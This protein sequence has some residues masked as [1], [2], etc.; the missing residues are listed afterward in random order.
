MNI[1]RDRLRLNHNTTKSQPP[2]PDHDQI[3]TTPQY[4]QHH[5]PHHNHHNKAKPQPSYNQ[6]TTKIQP[7][8]TTPTTHHHSRQLILPLLQIAIT[9]LPKR[10]RPRRPVRIKVL[11]EPRPNHPPLRPHAPDLDPVRPPSLLPAITISN[12]RPPKAPRALTLGT[13]ISSATAPRPRPSAARSPGSPSSRW[14]P[15]VPP[16]TATSR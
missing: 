5:T 7:N 11:V 1:H 14:D 8:T 12:S 4:P 2:Q 3:S 6:I 10:R 9:H 15:T 16:Q 13:P